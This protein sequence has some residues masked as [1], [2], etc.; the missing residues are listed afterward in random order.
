MGIGFGYENPPSDN[1]REI[2]FDIHVLPNNEFI[3]RL[4]PI[5]RIAIW[6]SP[7]EP[8]YPD[9]IK[10]FTEMKTNMRQIMTQSP[11]E[12]LELSL[13]FMKTTHTNFIEFARL[14]SK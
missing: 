11:K 1:S 6:L 7:K 2:G 13:K 8:S 14:L 5:D 3:T 12:G 9:C 10:A 4:R